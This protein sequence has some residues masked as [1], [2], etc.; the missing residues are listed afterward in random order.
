MTPV[1]WRVRTVAL[2][3]AV[4]AAAG[5]T[6]TLAQG[7]DPPSTAA[8]RTV[9]G[10]NVFQLTAGSGSSTSASVVTGG[11][12]TFTNSSVEMHDV[13]FSTPPQGG[14]SCQQTAGGSAATALRFPDSPTAGTWAGTCT[15]TR[16]GTYS[17]ACDEHPGM[18]GTVV[19]SDPGG[20]TTVATTTTPTVT[21][22]PPVTTVP[23][24]TPPAAPPVTTTP[25][26]P[27]PPV[28]KSPA[29]VV[30]SLAV[31]VGLAQRGANVRGT[32]SGARSAARVE[33]TL[34]ARRGDL[35][36]TGRAATQSSIGKL[37]ALTSRSGAL[38]FSI[39]LGATARAALV[40]THRLAITV[41]ISAPVASGTI[42]R[43]T[44][45]IVVRSAG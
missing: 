35:R 27:A 9:D 12:V 8:F 28:D 15:F 5:I 2:M 36:L 6:A 11:S 29:A 22:P 41:S 20:M 45:R 43:R 24:G 23:A 30:R 39:R 21:T 32:I 19:V 37:S 4:V 42:A 3:L 18:T 17:F 1:G 40:R 14:L 31:S 33:V 25:S 13:D 44:F 16:A 7:D 38:T 34:T 10:P 26:S